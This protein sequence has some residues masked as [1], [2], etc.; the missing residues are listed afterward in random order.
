MSNK[1]E[2]ASNIVAYFM[3]FIQGDVIT[4]KDPYIPLEFVQPVV[5]GVRDIFASEPAVLQV[6][7]NINIVGDIHGHLF[8]L[9]HIFSHFGL[10]PDTR[11]LFLGDLVDRGNYSVQTILF[12]YALKIL[13]PHDIQIIRGNHE[14][15]KLS[16]TQGFYSDLMVAY[17]R[18][19][20]YELFIE[21]FQ[22]MPLAAVVKNSILCV[23]GGF[24]E[25]LKTIDQIMQISRPSPAGD[26]D[27]SIIDGL[28]WSDP[29]AKGSGFETSPRG[30]GRLFGEDVF[31]NFLKN[32]G[33][34]YLVRGH[35]CVE[36]G[37]RYMFNDRLITVFSASEYCGF[38]ENKAGVVIIDD[39]PFFKEYTFSIKDLINAKRAI[40][41]HEIIEKKKFSFNRK[42]AT[43]LI[44][45]TQRA[46]ACVKSPWMN[47]S[48]L[49]LSRSIYN[50][51]SMRTDDE[52][53]EDESL[54]HV[55]K[56]MFVLPVL[57]AGGDK[58][59]AFHDLK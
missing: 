11:F 16:K 41:S 22:Y 32:T 2:A 51:S 3:P 30:I 58:S 18:E 7:G 15:L 23:H 29:S 5:E 34:N 17:Q 39:S 26:S 55:K 42:S 13:F 56:S 8:D 40:E 57:R 46:I 27:N 21:S 1:T 36:K 35:E 54:Q 53:D 10:P 59:N 33:M 19:D 48:K 14:S 49:V 47:K 4:M 31:E 50:M 37:V 44:K 25:N 52:D 9:Y 12:L 43:V 38:I 45:K 20:L 24:D 28:L 6:D